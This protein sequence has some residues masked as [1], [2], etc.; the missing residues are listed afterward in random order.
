MVRKTNYVL[1]ANVC[2]H[3][4]ILDFV[5]QQKKPN[6]DANNVA[7]STANLRTSKH[8]YL[9]CSLK[10]LSSHFL[11]CQRWW[12]L[13]SICVWLCIFVGFMLVWTRCQTEH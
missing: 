7:K 2:L 9:R 10:V 6:D 8:L 3:I 12:V 4:V 5:N 11:L 1:E 13:L